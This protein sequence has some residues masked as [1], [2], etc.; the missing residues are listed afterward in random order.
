MKTKIIIT[1]LLLLT[2][3]ACSTAETPP[4]DAISD[5]ASTAATGIPVTKSPEPTE[6]I[7]TLEPEII[8]VSEC[9]VVSTLSGLDGTATGDFA[10]SEDDW[11][12]GS[13]DARITIVE[14]GDF[15]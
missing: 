8:P 3:A 2:T 6:L 12:V 7:P 4:V 11:V 14:Y 10:I 1:F 9:T 13:D 15:Q 5:T